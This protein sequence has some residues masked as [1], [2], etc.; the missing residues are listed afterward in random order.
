MF[1]PGSPGGE[2]MLGS[3][4]IYGVSTKPILKYHKDSHAFVISL[5]VLY[6]AN[7][8]DNICVVRT[9]HNVPVIQVE[10]VESVMIKKLL[11]YPVLC[12]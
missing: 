2:L 11:T 1:L 8:L 5:I 3:I 7:L 9:V 10:N 6:Y 4:S 12:L